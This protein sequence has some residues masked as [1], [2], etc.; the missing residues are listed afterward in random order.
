MFFPKPACQLLNS[1][2]YFPC[3]HQLAFGQQQW[4]C[5]LLA[6]CST[7]DNVWQSPAFHLSCFNF[8]NERFDWFA[9]DFQEREATPNQLICEGD[10]NW[11]GASGI[12]R[13]VSEDGRPPVLVFLPSSLVLPSRRESIKC[14]LGCEPA[15]RC[16]MALRTAWMCSETTVDELHTWVPV[17]TVRTTLILFYI[18]YFVKFT[19][20]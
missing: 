1:D 3:N 11:K 7:F 16:L 14:E 19:Y 5:F 2:F 15:H 9:Q 17:N 8:S 10:K 4:S 6:F 18:I 20:S 13:S 12:P